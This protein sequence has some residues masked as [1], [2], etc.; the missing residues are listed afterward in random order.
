MPKPSVPG[1]DPEGKVYTHATGT[2]RNLERAAPAMKNHLWVLTAKIKAEDAQTECQVVG[3]GGQAAGLML[4]FDKDVPVFACNHF[5]TDTLLQGVEQISEDVI[6][7]VT[8]DDQTGPKPATLW[9]CAQ[10]PKFI[11]KR[12]F[13]CDCSTL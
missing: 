4:C 3:F 1:A 13:L 10:Y 8:F 7:V 6:L 2:V 12:G 9:P 5:G 11:Q